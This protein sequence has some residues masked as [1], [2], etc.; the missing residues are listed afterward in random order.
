MT[1]SDLAVQVANNL[2]ALAKEEGFETFTEMKKSYM[3]ESQDI[4]DEVYY[5]ISHLN[6]SNISMW[7]DCSVVEIGWEQM[8]WGQF[9]KLVFGYIKK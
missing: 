5:I 9:K 2:L 3:W 1:F 7:D 6:N 8:R 4:K